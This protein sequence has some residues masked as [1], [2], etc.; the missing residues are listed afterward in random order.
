MKDDG[1]V[2]KLDR[3]EMVELVRRASRM[4]G[5]A[6]YIE[7][8]AGEEVAYEVDFDKRTVVRI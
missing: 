4:T 1:N 8:V 7:T 6:I 5:K 2:R 3:R